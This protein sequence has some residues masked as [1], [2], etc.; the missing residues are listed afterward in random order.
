MTRNFHTSDL[1][2]Y[3]CHFFDQSYRGNVKALTSNHFMPTNRIHMYK[4]IR[5]RYQHF[6]EID[7]TFGQLQRERKMQCIKGT[8][9]ITFYSRFEFFQSRTFDSSA[10]F[11]NATQFVIKKHSKLQRNVLCNANSMKHLH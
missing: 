7:V 8:M 5:T 6:Y 4:Y 3:I 9:H 11:H 1:S 10:A 2:F